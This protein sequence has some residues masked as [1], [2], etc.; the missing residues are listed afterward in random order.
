MLAED[1][2]LLPGAA[3]SGF[4]PFPGL[5]PFE[6]E[7]DYLFFGRERQIDE[8][9]RRLRDNRFLAIL[10]T[11]GC[12]KSS[13][14]RSGLIPSLLGGAMT[15]AGS[16]WRVALLRPGEDPLGNLAA[17]LGAAEVLAWQG[18]ADEL[19][20]SFLAATLRA[21]NRGLI[22]C[23]QQARLTAHDNLLVAIDQFEE[24]FRFKHASSRDDALAFCK[25]LLTG[26]R[27]LESRIYIA[28]TMRSDFVGDCMEFTGLPEAVNE[29]TYLV[30]RMLRDEL[31]AAITGPVAVGGGTI[32]PRLVARLLND[33]GD[34]PDQLPVLQHALMRTWQFWLEERAPG[35]PLDL[36]HY[37][38]I[39]TMRDALSRHCEEAYGELDA[40]GQRI[41]ELMFSALTQSGT[42]GRGIRRPVPLAEVADLTG[43]AVPE[44][45]AV[46]ERFRSPGR[47]FLMPVAGVPLHAGSVLDVSHES[48]MRLWRRLAGWVEDEARSAQ[49]Y[50][51]VARAAARHEAGTAALWRDPEL[52]LALSWRDR[53][54]PTAAWASRYDPGFERAM[55]FLDASVAERDAE[56]ARREELRRRE[57]RRARTLVLVLGIAALVTLVLGG[58]AYTQKQNAENAL[59]MAQQQERIAEQRGHQALRQADLAHRQ[60]RI[61]EEQSQIASQERANSERQGRAAEEQRRLAESERRKAEAEELVAKAK[62]AEALASKLDAEG[63]RGEAIAQRELANKARLAAEASE[64]ETRRLGILSWVRAVALQIVQSHRDLGNEPAALLAVRIFESSRANG[65]DPDDPDVYAALHVALSGLGADPDPVLRGYG[66]AVRALAVAPNGWQAFS[67]S[68]DGKVRAFDLR[69]PEAP[70]AVVGSWG[71]G[72]RALALDAAGN[73]LAAGG[74]GGEVRAWDLRKAGAPPRQLAPPVAPGGDSGRAE[75]AAGGKDRAA[76]AVIFSSLAFQPEARLLAAGA[77]D[78]TVRLWDLD[79]GVAARLDTGGK[80]VLAVA[81]SPD[82]RLLAA[83]LGQQGGALLWDMRRQGDPPGKACRDREV[84]ALAF[85]PS[86]KV[87]ACGTGQGDVQLRNPSG[88]R[89]AGDDLPGPAA[90]DAPRKEIVVPGPATAINAVRF[91]PDGAWLATGSSDGSVRLWSL[92]GKSAEPI[93]LQGHESWVWALVYSPDGTRLLSGGEDRTVRV[94]SPRSELLATR[95]CHQLHRDL[96]EEERR[97]Y[98]PSD[99]QPETGA[100]CRPSS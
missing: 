74:A 92:G 77:A 50:I 35:E 63:R 29:G 68:E 20:R 53:K 18:K 32:A 8:L 12:G 65:G 25:L 36:R 1:P 17:A 54:R 2:G 24:L 79:Q 71:A 21:S 70:A 84:R 80:K 7:E 96:T 81:F 6:P 11:S 82:G 38:A 87:L 62:A 90:R 26:A 15:R 27:H 60:R 48:L 98:L 19:D 67:G 95:I 22:E 64:R 91:S 55:R 100:T 45:A 33:V 94:W 49:I 69:R 30:P 51:G 75:A 46:V 13:L 66:D 16:S 52:Q 86:G 47:S 41:A 76:G 9:L 34:D 40:A 43:A 73:L 97:R 39:G 88:P 42:D 99:L 78:G 5:R 44:V 59:A 28:I 23:V 10:G 37:E 85:S 72:I 58:L 89:E 3:G 93:V 4:N 31:R 56:V 83:G 14:V 57:L 61:A